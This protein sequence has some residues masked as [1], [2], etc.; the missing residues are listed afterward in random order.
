MTSASAG[1][2][3]PST[4]SKVASAAPSQVSSSIVDH[5]SCMYT[6]VSPGTDRFS[7]RRGRWPTQIGPKRQI[8]KTTQNTSS[9]L[10]PTSTGTGPS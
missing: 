1:G 9:T 3:D 5:F 2:E 4:G 8:P 10:V 6:I 7:W